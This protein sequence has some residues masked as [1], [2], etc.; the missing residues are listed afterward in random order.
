MPSLFLNISDLTYSYE[1]L[2]KI[3]TY[4]S[5]IVSK[6]EFSFLKDQEKY[7]GLYRHQEVIK[8]LIL[9]TD[10]LL[11]FHKTGTGKSCAGFGS[12]EPFA[13]DFLSIVDDFVNNYV[14][15]KRTNIKRIF[16][17]TK[18]PTLVNSA[19]KELVCY[20]SQDKGK[21][22]TEDVLQSSTDKIFRLRLKKEVSKF[23]DFDTYY[24]FASTIGEETTD[25]DIINEYSNCM[26][27][28]DEVQTL[29]VV[30]EDSKAEETEENRKT[31][32]ILHRVF[33]LIQNAKIILMS[34]TPIIDKPKEI[35]GSMNLILPLDNQM[36]IPDYS[37]VTL[38]E[39]RKYF[40]GNVS[41]VGD[42]QDEVQTITPGPHSEDTE[43]SKI[44]VA[45]VFVGERISRK[46][47]ELVESFQNREIHDKSN[48]RV[49][50][51]KDLISD[52]QEK[53]YLKVSQSKQGKFYSKERQILNM[54]FPNESYETELP[55][56]SNH[57]TRLGPDRYVFKDKEITKDTF[58]IYSAK[59]DNIINE[60]INGKGNRFIFSNFVKMGV[61][62]LSA[63]FRLYGVDQF[64]GNT[65]AFSNINRKHT[66][67]YCISTDETQ[68]GKKILIDKKLR[69]AIIST[70]TTQVQIERIFE[71]FN[72]YENRFGE[73]IK[74]IIGSPKT[75][76]GISLFSIF[77]V[78]IFDPYWNFSNGYQ[79]FSRGF[80]RGSLRYVYD[81]LKD[82][83]PS[84]FL[85][86]AVMK[87][88]TVPT[89]DLILYTRG[90]GK[91]VGN[92]RIERFIKILAVDCRL[93][94]PNLPEKNIND[95]SP[96]CDYQK[97]K[98]ECIDNSNLPTNY[99]SFD[100][101]YSSDLLDE[102]I[103]EIK[104][105]FKTNFIIS[106]NDLILNLKD[107]YTEKQ[108]LL[109]IEK[110][111]DQ[112]IPIVN[113]FGF[114]SYIYVVS[115]YII[116]YNGYPD[117][118]KSKTKNISMTNYSQINVFAKDTNN[119]ES[120][121]FE[122]NLKDIS[123]YIKKYRKIKDINE[124]QFEQIYSYITSLNIEKQSLL[125]ESSIINSIINKETQYD[126][127]VLEYFKNYI[128]EYD[129]P[130]NS[131][132][133][134]RKYLEN[135]KRK[136]VNTANIKIFDELDYSGTDKVILN[137][138]LVNSTDRASYRVTVKTI[139]KNLRILD[140]KKLEKGMINS[141]RFAD[142]FETIIFNH[143]ISESTSI[144]KNIQDQEIYGSISHA[145]NNFR[146]HI[147]EHDEERQL[148]SRT[149][150]RGRKCMTFSIAKLI[151]LL[152]KF[153]VSDNPTS[154][155][156]V[157]MD[158]QELIDFLLS[159]DVSE[160]DIENVSLT[161]LKTFY[162]WIT[163]RSKEDICQEIAKKFEEKGLIIHT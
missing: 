96:I 24:K 110:L 119:L 60:C 124:E 88:K 17:L 70:E 163:R 5:Y 42:L 71:L 90:E 160:S 143:L 8:R 84:I 138:M 78:H 135:R 15:T 61:L 101:L 131:I 121:L 105:L 162:N 85:H 123:D 153:D 149:K 6:Y 118:E 102:I 114:E 103:S 26:F 20:C 54:T 144:P 132:I 44:Q 57:M 91:D 150:I 31:Y 25:Q 99:D 133:E 87:S 154:K 155:F 16:F 74:I 41:Y 23:Y 100:V 39:L 134:I 72:S 50:V 48:I 67:K 141:F 4:Q 117:I 73:Y 47:A 11:L 40:R 10:K 97:C 156:K 147:N 29:S 145:D 66:Q 43:T 51:T 55:K 81:L 14:S 19:R 92:K 148:D 95:Y 139:A 28:L 122:I 53:I 49:L 9:F 93:N 18:G 161:Y 58:K 151:S 34:A 113:R 106:I 63:G 89:I 86:C 79:A 129:Y 130:L 59:G 109:A 22:I 75:Q 65:S 82:I 98:Y 68:T 127:L 146:I 83:T 80:R 64:I 128:L 108:V 77:G 125:L 159:K 36:N 115:S 21:Y 104:D 137:T 30:E 111:Y 38:E 136:R 158:K 12:S 112:K 1:D 152:L 13:N 94:N 142:N 45:P 116:I 76:I 69:F 126:K 3:E 140:V 2:N 32:S 37:T 27:I 62:I 107:K 7:K 52:F 35:E 56:F 46:E 120:F 157:Q 33:H